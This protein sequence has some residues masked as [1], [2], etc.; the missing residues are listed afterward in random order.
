MHNYTK[1]F[2]LL[3]VFGA[4]PVSSDSASALVLVLGLC[5]G[6]HKCAAVTGIIV[7]DQ[8]AMLHCSSPAH[9][10]LGI[11]FSRCFCNNPEIAPLLPCPQ[12]TC[13]VALTTVPPAQFA[14]MWIGQQIPTVSWGTAQVGWYSCNRRSRLSSPPW[15]IQ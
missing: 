14:Q 12:R 2:S 5:F 13:G 9:H 6:L 11:A 7:C 1:G 10:W 3:I 4:G 15:P 8:L